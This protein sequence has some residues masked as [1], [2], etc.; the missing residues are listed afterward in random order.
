MLDN[1]SIPQVKKIPFP[2]D[3]D[4]TLGQNQGW[5]LQKI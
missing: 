5:K 2:E 3:F 4:K 1:T